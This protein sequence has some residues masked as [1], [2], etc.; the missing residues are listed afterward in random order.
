MLIW[1]LPHVKKPSGLLFKRVFDKEHF[2]PLIGANNQILAQRRDFERR[3]A[4]LLGAEIII[5]H[6]SSASIAQ[7]HK[8]ARRPGRFLYSSFLQSSYVRLPRGKLLS[9]FAKHLVYKVPLLVFI[10][11]LQHRS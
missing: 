5:I 2:E 3:Q 7:C 8:T 10:S 6:Y 4:Q 9:W 11:R 1:G